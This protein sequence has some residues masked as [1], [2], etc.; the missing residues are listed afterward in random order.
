MPRT[1]TNI[2][3]TT[4][5][6][7]TNRN[8]DIRY[9][10]KDFET[11]RLALI[12]FAKTYFS[13]SYRDFSPESTGMML[14]ELAAYIGDSLSFYLDQ[15]FKELFLESA[16]EK[17]N[18]LK[19]AKLLG[20]KP[21]GKVPSSTY[22]D[23]Y[24]VVPAILDGGTYRPDSGS[25]GITVSKGAVLSTNM[26]PVI[27]FETNADVDFSQNTIRDSSENVVYQYNTATGIPTH[28]LLKKVVKANAGQT[29]TLTYSVDSPTKYLDIKIDEENVVEIID[30]NDSENR[31]WYKVDYLTQDTIFKAVENTAANDPILSTDSDEV[32]YLL[33][34]LNISR[35]FIEQRDENGYLHAIFGSGISYNP[36]DELILNPWSVS[37]PL[38][39]SETFAS[40][41]I[42]PSNF[43]NTK[44]LGMAPYNTTLT[45]RYRVGGGAETNVPSNTI[46]DIVSRTYTLETAG[47]DLNSVSSAVNSLA[48]NNPMSAEGGRDEESIEEIRVNASANF[49][50]QNR[51]V[52][53][54]DYIV[55]TYSMPPKFGSIAKVFALPAYSSTP[56]APT[57]IY[58]PVS[59]YIYPPTEASGWDPPLSW[60]PGTWPEGSNP[61]NYSGLV[62]NYFKYVGTTE[63]IPL[64]TTIDTRGE[65]LYDRIGGNPLGVNL[66]VLAYNNLKQLTN[67][68][69]ALKRNIKNYLNKHRILTDGINIYDGYVV[70]IGVHFKV[71]ASRNYNKHEVLE[72]CMTEMKEF[73]KI[74]NIQFNQPII[75]SEIISKLQAVKGVVNV[76]DV[77]IVNLSGGN[78]SSYRYDIKGNTFSNVIYPSREVSV[79]EVKSPNTDIKGIVI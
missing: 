14:I 8:K 32:P 62:P 46:T 38:S 11:Y 9:V 66:Y 57:E 44:T 59:K 70:N 67:A 47:L 45:I 56:N 3:Y 49:S 73:F 5:E 75:L 50:T 31:E 72:R 30:I 2:P 17:R 79:F 33:K 36:D 76:A 41:A 71:S 4:T 61:P 42:D 21:K 63:G 23:M 54:E 28:Y 25:Y 19:I 69:T 6:L 60:I 68:S 10:S 43:M 7:E 77:S 74:E 34:M 22:I 20:Y 55:R 65:S 16:I 48:V 12:D 29:K 40:T 37:L 24:T 39:G 27:Y 13:D 64:P 52:T 78:Y 35:R 58:S 53:R 15:Q 1:N 26:T 18:I 51:I